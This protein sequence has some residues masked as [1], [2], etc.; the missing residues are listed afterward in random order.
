MIKTINKN[1]KIICYILAFII[2]VIFMLIICKS[3]HFYPFENV[4][5]VVADTKVQFISYFA[6]LKSVFYGNNDL[7]YSFSKIIGGDMAGFAF[8]YLG[9]PFIYLLLFVPNEMLPAGI[10]YVIILIIG[11][12]S[13]SFNI[14]INNIHGFRW[15]SLLFS[16]SYGFIGYFMAYYNC[17]LYFNNIMLLP[18][19]I[20]GLYEVVV[21]EKKSFK[22]I[23][24]LSV[25][26]ITNYYIGYMTCI[27]SVIMLVYF[28]VIYK[29]PS[30]NIKK[31]ISVLLK[32]TWQ[33]LLAVMISTV[34]LLTVVFSLRGQKID[35]GYGFSIPLGINFSLKDVFSGLYTISFNGNISDGL[36]I[37]YCGTLAG[38]FF[39]LFFINN[40]IK[41]KE[42]IVSLCVVIVMILSFYL[43]ALNLL[44]H[45]L[46]EPVGFPYRNSF[47]L[48]FLILI[49]SYRGFMLMKQ[50]TRKYHTLVVFSIFFLYS[51]YMIISHNIYV[52]KIQII[53]TGSFLVMILAGVY[54]ICYKREYMYPITIGFFLI[55]SFEVLINGYWSISKYYPDLES[56]IKEYDISLYQDFYN[57]N[58]DIVDYVNTDNGKLGNIFRMEKLYRDSHNDA[59]LLSYNGLSHFSSCES[60]N[61]IRFMDKLGFTTESLWSYYGCE[62]NTAFLDSFFG[63][64]YLISQYDE[65]PKPYE[66]MENM[67]DKYIF[68]NQYALDFAMSAKNGINEIDFDSYNHFTIQNAIAKGLTGESYGIYRPVEVKEI[69]LV[70]VEKYEK[71]YTRIDASQD[72]YVEYNLLINSSDFIYCYF[73]AEENQATDFV[74]NDLEKQDYF[75][76]YNWGTRV[77]GYFNPGEIIPV[78][79]YLKQD[80]IEIDSYEFYYES[81]EELERFYNDAVNSSFKTKKV[82]SSHIITQANIS[83]DEDMVIYSMPYDK[84]WTVK[85]DGKEV[86]TK[87][88]MGVLLGIDIEPGTHIID[89]SYTP[90]GLIVGSVI[91]GISVLILLIIYILERIRIRKLLKGE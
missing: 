82:T 17:I 5:P 9:N 59:M 38:A 54:A 30:K 7:F 10:M 86:E 79:I 67:H 45:G 15:S 90:Q 8:Y 13:L 52:G 21:K 11:L 4:N 48:S 14:M 53:L 47:F 89:L 28:Y 80:E 27:F 1:S 16:I 51:L 29:Q 77:V 87:P 31:H 18:I 78:R 63:V 40:E 72:A 61:V 42:K 85:V 62:G 35:D 19:I 81:K 50:G 20:L 69:N 3:L 66:Y 6:Y 32:Y 64:K 23:I 73:N 83:E 26:I 39:L 56:S 24:F 74:V 76:T 37:I 36:P 46:R 43:K 25:T 91:S 33:T 34:S 41:L 88:V 44:W 57:N 12:S 70:N 84:G 60:G 71:T 58:A 49:I 55:M 65:I 75:N 22:Y 2:P 68:K